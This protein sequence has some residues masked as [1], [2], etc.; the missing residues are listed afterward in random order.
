MSTKSTS[1]PVFSL[2]IVKN[3]IYYV[4]FVMKWQHNFVVLTAVVQYIDKITKIFFN[5]IKFK[6]YDV[7]N[8]STWFKYVLVRNLIIIF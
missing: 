8:K 3:N 5:L 1:F 6:F 4:K 2:Y 7:P